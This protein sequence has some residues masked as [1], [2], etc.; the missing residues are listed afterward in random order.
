MIKGSIQQEHITFLIIYAPNRGTP[1]YIKQILIELTEEIDSST[2]IVGDVNT[3]FISMDRSSRQITNK[4]TLDLNDTLA[5]MNLIDIYR[6]F[7]PKA[8]EYTF[9]HF[10]LTFIFL[11]T[12]YWSIVDLQC[13]VS[14]CSRAK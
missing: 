11:I 3:S 2:V 1:K 14:F 6:A 5:Q 9:F 10:S 4:E 7:H 8:A 13:C 12:F